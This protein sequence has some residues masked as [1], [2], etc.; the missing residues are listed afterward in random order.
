MPHRRGRDYTGRSQSQPASSV[1]GILLKQTLEEALGCLG[2]LEPDQRL[3]EIKT[4]LA[5]TWICGQGS[6]EVSFGFTI[7]AFPELDDALREIKVVGLR[8]KR[9]LRCRRD[10][11]CDESC[12]QD[13]CPNGAAHATFTN[14]SV[15]IS[16]TLSFLRHF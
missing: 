14:T 4:G 12:P 10:T 16:A 2:P 1:F 6:S 9:T 8:I 13:H 7:L 3:P 15:P 11:P 5:V